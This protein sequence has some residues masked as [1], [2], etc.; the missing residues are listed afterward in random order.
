MASAGPVST[1]RSTAPAPEGGA[2]RRAAGPARRRS[3]TKQRAP[4]TASASAAPGTA[5]RPWSNPAARSAAVPRSAPRRAAGRQHARRAAG[6]RSAAADRPVRREAGVRARPG[7]A[8]RAKCFPRPA[9]ARR[10]AWPASGMDRLPNVP[11]V[12]GAQVGVALDEAHIGGIHRQFL[13]DQQPQRRLVV[14]PD[15]DLAGEGG[16]RPGRPRHAATRPPSRGHDPAGAGGGH[17]TTSP[18]PSR[19]TSPGPPARTGPTAARAGPAPRRRRTARAASGRAVG[20]AA[21]QGSGPVHRA[22]DPRIAAAPAQRRGPAPRRS[23]RRR[24]RDAPASSAAARSAMPGVQYPHCDARSA[25]SARCTGC[26][27]SPAASARPSI[28][29]TDRPAASPGPLP[30]GQH[31]QA[32]DEHRARAARTL[33][34]AFLDSGQA[35]LRSQEGKQALVRPADL[36]R[37]GVDGSAAHVSFALAFAARLSS[38]AGSGSRTGGPRR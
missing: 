1:D 7:A 32:V 26:S 31:R 34:A 14:L 4:V 38:S 33:A 10:S 21:G 2:R 11:C 3:D 24:D 6:H 5:A 17:T 22:D 37:L 13:R 16:H 35:Q 15:V 19:R 36:A 27:G 28:V 25:I 29:V 18:S 12:I 30:A 8:A 9:A 20:L 23:D